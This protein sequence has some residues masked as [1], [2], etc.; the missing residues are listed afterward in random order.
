[1]HSVPSTTC[2]PRLLF[3]RQAQHSPDSSGHYLWDKYLPS[4]LLLPMTGTYQ[5]TG[6]AGIH[7][8]ASLSGPGAASPISSVL[9]LLRKQGSAGR[10]VLTS[11]SRRAYPESPHIG[12][13]TLPL[14]RVCS[15]GGVLPRG[16]GGC[17]AVHLLN[18]RNSALWCPGS[19]EMHKMAAKCAGNGQRSPAFSPAFWGLPGRV[20]GFSGFCH[21]VL[22][23]TTDVTHC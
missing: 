1:M 23:G 12:T 7:P 21:E 3:P 19:A 15:P 18:A 16:S 22:A 20:A 4:T 13:Q 14:E 2:T 10:L 6:E 9:G 5:K 11:A 8:R 17:P